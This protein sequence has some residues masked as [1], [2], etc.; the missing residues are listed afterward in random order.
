MRRKYI[1]VASVVSCIG[2]VALHCNGIFWERPQGFVW[3]SA[4][5]IECV[6]YFAAPVFFMISGATLMEYRNRY[7]TLSF[8]KRRFLR[9]VIPFVFW[10]CVAY[11]IA[12]LRDG[13]S[14]LSL[15]R[16]PHDIIACRYMKI[17]WFFI[18]LILW[19]L[20]VPV[21]SLLVGRRRLLEYLIVLGLVINC[22]YPFVYN[23]MSFAPNGGLVVYP[24][25]GCMILMLIG[26]Y[27]DTYDLSWVTRRLLYIAGFLSL[28]VHYF[29]TN[30]LSGDSVSTMLKG[31]TTPISIAYSSA[32]FVLFK[33][34]ENTSTPSW[35]WRVV[36][37]LRGEAFGV[38]LLHGFIVYNVFP[39]F[40]DD[41]IS[42]ALSYRVVATMFV[43]LCCSCISKLLRRIRYIS[44]V[45]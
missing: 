37:N 18:P 9:V 19:Y 34:I 12:I 29:G 13:F 38:Y 36:D 22:C 6:F 32:V 25:G 39:L 43:V 44:W 41:S 7:D 20:S 45:I 17:F 31:Y 42:A 10:S 5:A 40:I 35:L 2:V 30:Y 33:R 4:N 3:W 14:L 23:L 21:F 27:F 28:L 1:D 11:L 15:V 8:L 26:Y 24:V 16:L